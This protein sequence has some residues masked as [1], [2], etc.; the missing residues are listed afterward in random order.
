MASNPHNF[1][2]HTE[3]LTVGGTCPACHRDRAVCVA[4]RCA[5]RA[6]VTDRIGRALATLN[7]K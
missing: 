2:T 1:L 6:E 5:G 3:A 7:R 4:D